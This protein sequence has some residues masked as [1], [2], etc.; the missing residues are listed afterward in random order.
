[1]PAEQQEELLELLWY[2]QLGKAT[3]AC[4]PPM[5]HSKHKSALQQRFF[6]GLPFW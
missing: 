3:V 6:M 5:Q 2:I 4:Y 1:M